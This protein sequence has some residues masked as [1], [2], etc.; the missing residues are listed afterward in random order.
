MGRLSISHLNCNRSVNNSLFI[1]T[2]ISDNL[3]DIHLIS[4]NEPNISSRK[5]KGLE[6]CQCIFTDDSKPRAAVAVR[7]KDN[8]VTILPLLHLSDKDCVVIQVI[9]SEGVKFYFISSYF[10]PGESRESFIISLN[11]LSGIIKT[12]R[13]NN[14]MPVV[15]CSDTNS[16]S[17]EWGEPRDAKFDTFRGREFREFMIDNDLIFNRGFSEPTFTNS[18][19]GTSYIDIIATTNDSIFTGSRCML[20][21][22]PPSDH[23]FLILTL[24]ENYENQ[25]RLSLEKYKYKRFKFKVANSEDI[26]KEFCVN[27]TNN[28]KIIKN[29]NF[30]R[31]NNRRQADRAVYKLQYLLTAT[32]TQTFK[33]VS[34][35][36]GGKEYYPVRYAK[37]ALSKLRKIR[38]RWRK[39]SALKKHN[40][41]ALFKSGYVGFLKR[42][43]AHYNKTLN[44]NFRVL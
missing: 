24:D 30:E 17:Y 1:Q 23:R 10:C 13:E 3:E 31:I 33:K 19:G 14:N 5:I 15:L 34:T 38:S 7:G 32:C 27:L 28:L 20:Y 41:A 8:K 37:E 36:V 4:L 2:Y 39:Y 11:K 35:S 44:E 26:W 21:G 16:R 12:L 6:V 25:D 29:V 9:L 40:L 43:K 22:E 42:F 18:T